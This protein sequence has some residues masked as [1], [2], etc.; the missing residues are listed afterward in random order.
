[1]KTS[2]TQKV[3]N[4]ALKMKKKRCW[5]EL[6]ARKASDPHSQEHGLCCGT[7]WP[8]TLA[9]VLGTKWGFLYVHL[10][11]QSVQWV[12]TVQGHA[13]Q[14]CFLRIL[15]GKARTCL[16]TVP[17]AQFSVDENPSDNWSM[18]KPSILCLQEKS[19]ELNLWNKICHA[20]QILKA[21]PKL[22]NSEDRSRSEGQKAHW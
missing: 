22:S 6:L 11:S 3:E 5:K 20:G 10:F 12:R 15:Q 8:W 19:R 16:S 7:G 13:S 18:G 2:S 17:T 14:T 1:M 4:I 21:L 9:P